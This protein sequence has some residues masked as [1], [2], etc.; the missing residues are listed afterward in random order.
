MVQDRKILTKFL[1]PRVV[2]SSA[3]FF[4][5]IVFLAILAGNFVGRLTV[6]I[7]GRNYYTE[8]DLTKSLMLIGTLCFCYA[9][10][11]SFSPAKQ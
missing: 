4:A 2:R 5:K 7:N 3:I 11:I 9:K 8:E 6:W 1:T 10:T